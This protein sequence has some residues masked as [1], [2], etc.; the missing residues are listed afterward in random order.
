MPCSEKIQA[1]NNINL[2]HKLLVFR[3]LKRLDL[4]T[5]TTLTEA[6]SIFAK[7]NYNHIQRTR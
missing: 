7:F 5:Y 1:N 4:N 3:L 2:G 6:V